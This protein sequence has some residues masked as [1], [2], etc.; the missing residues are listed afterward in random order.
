MPAGIDEVL[1]NGRRI[2][3]GGAYRPHPAGEVLR[4]GA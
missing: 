3:A 1:I 2:V 4:R